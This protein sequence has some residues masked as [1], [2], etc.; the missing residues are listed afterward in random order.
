MTKTKKKS[1]TVEIQFPLL[2]TPGSSIQW[3][4]TMYFAL[5][6]RQL[7]QVPE[8]IRL[9]RSTLKLIGIDWGSDNNEPVAAS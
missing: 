7:G 4:N 8:R 1:R 6:E 9:I 3:K 2:I 5:K